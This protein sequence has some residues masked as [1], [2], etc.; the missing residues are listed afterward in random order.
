[1][2]IKQTKHNFKIETCYRC[3]S[4]GILCTDRPELRCI[5]CNCG[6]MLISIN[7]CDVINDWN[8]KQK[9]VKLLLKIIEEKDHRQHAPNGFFE[10][11]EREL[12]L[13]YDF[14]GFSM[15]FLFSNI[16]PSS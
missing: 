5:V 1:M 4:P 8:R 12:S 16:V 10:V 7:A 9:A 14:L 2:D 11:E 13:F 15:S 3:A 6:Q